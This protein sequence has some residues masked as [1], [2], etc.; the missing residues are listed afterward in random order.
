MYQ[1]EQITVEIEQNCWNVIN[2]SALFSNI[3]D[4]A[5]KKLFQN[6]TISLH[7]ESVLFIII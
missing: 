1:M 2:I 7:N 3:L 5:L 4:I 6:R